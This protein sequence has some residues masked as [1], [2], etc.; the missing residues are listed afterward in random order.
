M[1][2]DTS[3]E[4]S[5]AAAQAGTLE[6]AE[7]VFLDV[8]RRE[9]AA[10]PDVAGVGH[11][12]PGLF[13][14]GAGAGEALCVELGDGEVAYS[15]AITV[16]YEVNIPKMVEGLRQRLRS[17]VHEVTGYVVRAVNVTVEHILP[18]EAAEAGPPPIPDD[19][20]PAEPGGDAVA[21]PPP[22]PVQE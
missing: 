7:Q 11:R 20:P 1:P 6:V 5:D 4:T 9:I 17:A 19:Q 16:A 8:V 15:V 22:I 13:R 3:P 2:E 12:A 21:G 14:R 18:P 10:M